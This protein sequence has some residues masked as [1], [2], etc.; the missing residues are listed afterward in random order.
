MSYEIEI[1]PSCHDTIKKLCKKNPVLEHALRNKVEEIAENPDHY[2]PLKYGLAGER[3]VHI[4]KSFVLRFELDETRKTITF[5][6]FSHHDD[7]Y[8]R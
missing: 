1:T 4:M 8:R 6:A 5:L 3:R 2:K 7:V